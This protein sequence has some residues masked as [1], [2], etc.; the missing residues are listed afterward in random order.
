MPVAP[1]ARRGAARPAAPLAELNASETARCVRQVV[2]PFLR[3]APAPLLLSFL[4]DV[5]SPFPLGL[6]AAAH[7]FPLAL[8]GLGHA[9]S[10]AAKL[11]GL[12][13]ALQLLAAASPSLPAL[14]ADGADAAL[15][16]GASALHRSLL[17]AGVW[18]A[19]ECAS[20]PVCLAANY[21]RLPSHAACAARGS[22]CFANSGGGGG[23]AVS[24]LALL[25]AAAAAQEAGE[26]ADD[27]AAVHAAYL[28]GAA[29][30]RLDERG[31]LFLSLGACKGGGRARRVGGAEVCHRG[32][33]EP[34]EALVGR[35][36]GVRLADGTRPLLLHAN[37]IHDRLHRVWWGEGRERRLPPRQ[38]VSRRWRE[39]TVRRRS[40]WRHPVLLIDSVAGGTCSVTTLEK[41]LQM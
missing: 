35:G 29:G 21:S 32:A 22:L 40:Q 13:R 17:S 25:R 5:P 30:G 34:L 18:L 10:P 4:T 26:R 24:L 11:P 3:G 31:A 8:A 39:E 6:T 9:W 2:G 38:N 37:G 23:P 36:E 27:Q 20:W 16:G 14:F 19:A 12:V 41:L 15:S 28:A 1:M 7:A 33:Y